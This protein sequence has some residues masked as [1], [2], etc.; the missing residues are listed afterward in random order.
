MGQLFTF[1]TPLHTSTKRDTLGRMNDDK[2]A[3]MIQARKY[4][5]D[6][7][8]GERRFG[9]GG[10]KYIPG[11]WQPMAKSLIEQYSL[12][13]R[14]RVL[15]VGCG[16]AY[17]L[18]EMK[19]LLPGLTISGF[20]ISNYGISHAKEE[21]RDSLFQHRAQDVYPFDDNAFD[22]VISLG[23]LH[24]LR[25]PELEIAIPEISRVGKAQYIM[26]ESYRNESELFNLQC[27]ALTAESFLEVDE[28][29][30][31]YDQLHYHG[32]FEFIFFE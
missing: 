22:L 26:V 12:T 23:C 1:F 7:W 4:G 21:I 18:Y 8:D 14:S 6:Y 13:D 11:W 31:L 15:D 10:Y 30:W 32:D 29:L 17:L 28:W 3:C 20:D 2:V 5:A 25:L 19:L 27:W 24:N 16:K 9:Y